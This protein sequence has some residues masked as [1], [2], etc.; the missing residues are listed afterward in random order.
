MGES[1]ESTTAGPLESQ[2][3]Q[4][5]A[6]VLQLNPFHLPIEYERQALGKADRMRNL[7]SMMKTL[8]EEQRAR[9]EDELNRGF[10]DWL[11]TSGNLRQVLDLVHLERRGGV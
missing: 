5:L 10:R 11:V 8:S 3:N 7:Q 6:E 9:L 2:Y 1:N 4:M